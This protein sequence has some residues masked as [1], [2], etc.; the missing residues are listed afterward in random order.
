MGSKCRIY[1]C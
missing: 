1:Y